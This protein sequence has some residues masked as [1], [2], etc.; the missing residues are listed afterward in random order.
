MSEA[1]LIAETFLGQDLT[2][3]ECE[4]LSLAVTHRTLEKGDIL[5]EEGSTDETLYILISGKLEVL[6]MICAE[7]SVSI[8]TLQA[9]AMTG[10]LSFIDGD[11]HSMRLVAKKPCDVLLLQK[12][13]FES[14]VE[15]EPLLTYHVMR[16]IVRYSHKLQRK[17]S[18]KYLEMRRLIQSQYTSQ[19]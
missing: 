18:A 19:Y 8:D 4:R 15:K 9:G 14:L 3:E 6:K 12:S 13:A 16:S 10:E 11:P 17:M 2:S 5:F 7:T 1:S